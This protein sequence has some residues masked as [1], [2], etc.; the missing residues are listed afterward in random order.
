MPTRL[1]DLR[2]Q[3]RRRH[4]GQRV[5]LEHERLAGR[6]RSA[7]P[8]ARG[9]CSRARCTRRARTARRARCTSARQLG[10]HE[11]LRVGALVLRFVV[12]ELRRRAAPRRSRARGRRGCRRTPRCRRCS[13]RRSPGRETCARA[14]TAAA[15][16]ARSSTMLTPTELP[17]FAGLTTNGSGK[18]ASAAAAS[19]PSAGPS[20][21][22]QAPPRRRHAVATRRCA[23]DIT[24][25]IA[26][27]LARMPEPVHGI[28]RHAHR[29]CTAP[30][31]PHVPCSAFHTTARA[32]VLEQPRRGSCPSF[33]SIADGVPALLLQ[34]REHA[35][36]GVERDLALGARGRP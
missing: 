16:C 10:R 15:S 2:Q 29:P 4:A 31:S 26:S 5:D 27:A 1:R 34:R 3:A 13:P 19:L 14:A 20:C 30:S 17:S 8:G 21:G 23:C 33:Q 22:K 32:G 36:A 35:G 18:S 12:V 6:A 11:V 9:R 7:D 25:S 24:L 28:R